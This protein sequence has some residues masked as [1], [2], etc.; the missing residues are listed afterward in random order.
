MKRG[1]ENRKRGGDRRGNR[2]VSELKSKSS[3]DLTVNRL[4][5]RKKEKKKGKEV[6]IG[7]PLNIKGQEMEK[8][9]V[10][11]ELAPIVNYLRL[12]KAGGKDLKGKK[13]KKGVRSRMGP[14]MPWSG[15]PKLLCLQECK[16]RLLRITE[17]K[18]A[19]GKEGG[20]KG[21][22]QRVCS[23]SA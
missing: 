12:G 6:G 2:S 5:E 13:R 23:G 3:G 9:A 18:F 19:T 4:A 15:G 17:K 10:F 22:F 14:R 21:R 16:R 20:G 11:I 7:K 1:R 8:K